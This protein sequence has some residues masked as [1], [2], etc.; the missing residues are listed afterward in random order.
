MTESR[1]HSTARSQLRD[2]VKAT[3]AMLRTYQE[4]VWPEEP[5][6]MLHRPSS[7]RRIAAFE[8]VHNIRFPRTYRLFL[9][10]HNG[11]ENYVNGFT[12]LGVTGRHTARALADV[13]LTVRC[14]AE[15]W[16]Q[17]HGTP[18]IAAIRAYEREPNPLN[19]L[20]RR[21]LPYIPTKVHFATDFNGSIRF[22]ASAANRRTS[23]AT[24]VVWN[25][26]AGTVAHY[27][28]FIAM[29][30][31]DLRLLRRQVRTEHAERT[32][33]RTPHHA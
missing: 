26:H 7:L 1:P 33:R 8:R 23:E 31:G 18:S 2:A 27:P 29:L 11:W 9:Q 3:H 4:L 10:M 24:V 12:L 30:R 28:N 13:R 15:A 16:K 25:V 14:F 22:F 5:P 6:S 19:R 32:R 20:E 17:A 21:G